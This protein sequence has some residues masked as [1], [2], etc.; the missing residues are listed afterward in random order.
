MVNIGGRFIPT[1]AGR[2]SLA[3]ARDGPTEDFAQRR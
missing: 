3:T 1:V 2:I